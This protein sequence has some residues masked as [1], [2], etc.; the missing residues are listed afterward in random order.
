MT[1]TVEPN[2]QIGDIEAVVK[3]ID[4]ACDEG[5]FK[6]WQIVTEVLNVRNRL[7]TFLQSV[8][9]KTEPEPQGDEPPLSP[10]K[11]TS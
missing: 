6:G 7:A 2:I 3:I 11:L 8:A 4:H 9:P 10:S 5:A 1:E